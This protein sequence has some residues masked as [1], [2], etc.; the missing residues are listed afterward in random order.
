MIA[1]K[2]CKRFP[3]LI[4]KSRGIIEVSVRGLPCRT[5]RATSTQ[6]L[7]SSG[8]ISQC[9]FHLLDAHQ[10][11]AHQNLL[12]IFATSDKTQSL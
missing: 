5:G 4:T 1:R 10:K 2:A 12:S 11:D 9:W 3:N 7:S 6:A 8:N